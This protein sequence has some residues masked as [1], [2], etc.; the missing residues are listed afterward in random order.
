MRKISI[1]NIAAD[2]AARA[3]RRLRKKTFMPYFSAL[4]FVYIFIIHYLGDKPVTHICYNYAL[5][6]YFSGGSTNESRKK[7]KKAERRFHCLDERKK[8]IY[9]I[10]NLRNTLYIGNGIMKK[11]NKPIFDTMVIDT[12]RV[13]LYKTCSP[14]PDY[15]VGLN[16]MN[17]DYPF[18]HKHDHWEI[19]LVNSGSLQHVLNG[20]K[21]IM[22]MGELCLLRPNDE[23]CLFINAENTTHTT[24]LITKE[25]IR[26]ILANYSDGLYEETLHGP[27]PL[28]AQISEEM[29]MNITNAAMNFKSYKL[30]VEHKVFYTKIIINKILNILIEAATPM[31]SNNPEWMTNFLLLLNNPYLDTT[32]LVKLAS[33]TPYSYSRLAHIFKDITGRT[34][35]EYCNHVKIKHAKELLR[36][37]DMTIGEICVKLNF[38]SFSYFHRLFKNLTG[39]TPNEYRKMS[40]PLN[41]M[42]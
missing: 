35:K 23:H 16:W 22:N 10:H 19:L 40:V 33:F 13:C 32:D 15:E 5:I 36:C 24:F 11:N 34:I 1:F 18:L 7:K 4:I 25:Y 37:S 27:N 2:I 12:G 38:E 20:E 8:M 30:K 28:C 6:C 14:Y 39:Y 41:D 29:L 9:N 26:K 3:I 17:S 42:E 21:T 31:L